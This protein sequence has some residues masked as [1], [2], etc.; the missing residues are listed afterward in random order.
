MNKTTIALAVGLVAA[1][2]GFFAGSYAGSAK[3]DGTTTLEKDQKWIPLD[4]KAGDKGPQVSVVFG[5]LKVKGPIGFFLKVPAGFKPGPHTHSS[6]DYAVIVKGSMHNFAVGDKTPPDEGP[7]LTAGGS[8]FQP[9]K[10]VHDNH[11]DAGSECVIYVYMSGGFDLT[12]APAP[13]AATPA[14][15]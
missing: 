15:K 5:D 8:W 14:K 3:K 12:P 11:C 10:Q 4:A 2:T 1:S 6:D 13:K 9:A 7:G